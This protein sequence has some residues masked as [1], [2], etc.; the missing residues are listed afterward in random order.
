MFGNAEVSQSVMMS[1]GVRGILI[2]PA[3]TPGYRLAEPSSRTLGSGLRSVPL[4]LV[5]GRA[6]DQVGEPTTPA[7]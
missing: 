5:P 4:I 1:C 3:S 6:P 2:A 7:L